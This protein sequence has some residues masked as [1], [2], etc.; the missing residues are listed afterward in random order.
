M[1]TKVE[2]SDRE[3]PPPT[4][5]RW[6]DQT[7]G[8]VILLLIISMAFPPADW[9]QEG[10]IWFF[11]FS[12]PPVRARYMTFYDIGVVA[13]IFLMGMSMNFTLRLETQALPLRLGLKKLL[14]RAGLLILLGYAILFFETGFY[15]ASPPENTMYHQLPAI[16]NWNVFLSIG[17]AYLCAIPWIFSNC[18]KLIIGIAYIWLT[19]Y[20][21]LLQTT[22]LKEYAYQSTHGGL[23]GTLFSL[24]AVAII[25][26]HLG[27]LIF[28]SSPIAKRHIALICG[29]GLIHLIVGILLQVFTPWSAEKALYS[30][31]YVVISIGTTMVFLSLFMVC[32]LVRNW[33]LTLFRIYGRYTLLSYLGTGT[34]FFILSSFFGTDFGLGGR[35]SL[36]FAYLLV[37][38]SYIS[39]YFLANRKARLNTTRIAI[40]FVVLGVFF[41]VVSFFI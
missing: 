15:F 30:L 39:L 25:G 41:L 34:L 38:I 29:V 16:V 2:N 33:D 5:I 19:F 10:T 12:H 26:N 36:L 22:F 40:F 32:D 11:F 21:I 7:R 4:R 31:S 8:F 28:G 27:K 23:F 3:T 1:E 6:L 24:S 35:G 17:V 13:F 9:K 14:M 37:L 20:Q 18:S